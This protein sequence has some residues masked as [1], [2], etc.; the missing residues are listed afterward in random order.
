MRTKR[1]ALTRDPERVNCGGAQQERSSRRLV[2]QANRVERRSE[3]QPNPAMRVP[4]APPRDPAARDFAPPA[5][6]AY[7]NWGIQNAKHGSSLGRAKAR[8]I[9]RRQEKALTKR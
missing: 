1:R 3:I 7:F 9:A 8:H 4:G 6:F 5:S 2:R